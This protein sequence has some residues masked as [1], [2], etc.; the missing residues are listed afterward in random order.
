MFSWGIFRGDY[1]SLM[2]GG[3]ATQRSAIAAANTCDYSFPVYVARYGPG[4]QGPRY[5]VNYAN[6]DLRIQSGSVYRPPS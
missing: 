5:V 4:T 2:T 3:F 6:H 1:D